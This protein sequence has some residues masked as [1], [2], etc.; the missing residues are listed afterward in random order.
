[1]TLT[2]RLLLAAGILGLA[3]VAQYALQWHL[4]AAPQGVYPELA[5]RLEA[6]PMTL[7]E[8]SD[9]ATLSWQGVESGRVEAIRKRLDFEVNGILS[10]EYYP[11]PGGPA[12]DLY[13]VYSR[14]A[15]DRKHHPEICMREASGYQQDFKADGIVYLDK[16][17]KRPVQRMAFHTGSG[18]KTTVYYWHY[19]FEPANTAGLSFLQL[20]QQKLSSP[21]PSI[22]V[23]VASTAPLA[24]L[25]EAVE[26]GFLPLL[27]T[28]M[29]QSFV[30]FPNRVGC[31]RL[32]VSFV[33]E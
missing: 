22:T 10:R 23:Q 1:M 13:M 11:V 27:D 17:Q 7:G 12:V 19:S 31:D 32:P 2:T 8:T 29:Q 6:L 30:P 26:K 33:R 21:V 9:P 24:D 25:K 14:S 15:G 28:T 3:V 20:L 5:D 16:E 18:V 4:D